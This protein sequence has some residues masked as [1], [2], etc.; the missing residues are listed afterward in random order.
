MKETAIHIA[1]PEGPLKVGAY[2]FG[3]W[4]VHRE[5]NYSVRSKTRWSI[6]HVA[7]GRCIP[8]FYTEDLSKAT[9]LKVAKAIDERFGDCKPNK[10]IGKAIVELIWRVSLGN[11][12]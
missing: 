6:T 7:S 12:S 4:A 11:K 1:M 2:V 5:I 10:K 9:A 8:S 3:A